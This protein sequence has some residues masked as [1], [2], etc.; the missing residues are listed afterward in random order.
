M[1]KG[2]RRPARPLRLR[3]SHLRLIRARASNIPCRWANMGVGE[4]VELGPGVTQLKEGDHI[5][6]YG[7]FREEHVWPESA[8]R[9][10][11]DV[12]WQ[13]AVCLDPSGFCPRCRARR[14]RP[15]RRRRSRLGPRSHQPDG[16]AI[17]PLGRCP[18]H[19]RPRPIVQPTRSSPRP[20]EPTSS[21][22]P[23]QCDA[24]LE[25]KKATANRGA[26]VIIDYS[27]H[28]AAMQQALRGVAY[29]GTIVAGAYP[30]AWTTGIDLGAEAHMNRPAHRILARQQR[31]KPR[32]PQLGQHP[33][34]RR[35]LA[36]AR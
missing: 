22:T 24:G 20:A 27:G 7:P 19:H 18:S 31:A 25:I 9:L 11:A 10:P 35:L 5:F 15:H 32:P 33:H 30:G 34:L 1:F 29:R 26:D 36:H 6:A 4:V 3:A 23:T 17:L 8:R 12:P 21:S 14:T 28:P 13:A 16:R 2:I